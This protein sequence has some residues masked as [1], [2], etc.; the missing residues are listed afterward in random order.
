MKRLPL[1]EKLPRSEKHWAEEGMTEAS[2]PCTSD[3]GL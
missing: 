1:S 3:R 2:G